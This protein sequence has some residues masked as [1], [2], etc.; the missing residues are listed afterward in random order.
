MKLLRQVWEQLRQDRLFSAIYIA[1]V[2]LAIATTM[3]F[4]IVYYVKL[5]PVYPEY[6]RANTYTA[7][8][9]T[10][11]QEANGINN[12]AQYSFK[13]VKELF[14]PLQNAEAVSAEYY[15]PGDGFIQPADGSSEF[16]VSVRTVDRSEERRVGKECL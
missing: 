11:K 12:T 6:N 16:E 8:Y 3:V 7:Q 1:G 10:Y 4:A 2:A 13:A 15:Y 9:S 14:M 5:A